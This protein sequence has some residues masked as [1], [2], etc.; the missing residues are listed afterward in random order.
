MSLTP[1]EAKNRY[2]QI[3]QYL[4]QFPPVLQFFLI[5]YQIINMKI[6]LVNSFDNNQLL[7]YIEIMIKSHNSIEFS[8][9]LTLYCVFIDIW[10]QKMFRGFKNNWI[11]INNIKNRQY[12]KN[13]FNNAEGFKNKLKKNNLKQ[14]NIYQI[15]IKIVWIWFFR[16]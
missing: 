15:C 10:Y 4:L 1:I 14:A 16:I 9:F 5:L 2:V 3:Y 13:Y 7:K 12:M 8:D 11:Y 6:R